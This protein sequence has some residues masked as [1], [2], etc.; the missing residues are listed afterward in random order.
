M[1]ATNLGAKGRTVIDLLKRPV[2]SQLV[3]RRPSLKD[4]HEFS[5]DVEGVISGVVKI[6]GVNTEGVKLGIYHRSNMN[7]ISTTISSNTG[8]YSFKYLDRSDLANYYVV[9]LDPRVS[10]QWNYTLANDH[11][12]AG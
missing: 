2:V 4:P 6:N 3:Y 10:L 8:A 9:C 11:L 12:S 5:I 1:A 7:L